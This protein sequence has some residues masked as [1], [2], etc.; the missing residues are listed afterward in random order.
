MLMFEDNTIRLE[1]P[2][3]YPETIRITFIP[4][5]PGPLVGF[6]TYCENLV[7]HVRRQ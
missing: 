2:L 5:T 6:F 1:L 7:S 4:D 3:K